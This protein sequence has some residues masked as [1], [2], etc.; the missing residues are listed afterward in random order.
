[1][2]SGASRPPLLQRA[3]VADA[4]D[5]ALAEDQAWFWSES[6]QAGERASEVDLVEGRYQDFDTMEEMLRDLG[7]IS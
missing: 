3:A 4:I 1:M 5:E 7:Q 2:P 6:W